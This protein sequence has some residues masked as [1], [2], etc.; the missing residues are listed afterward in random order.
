LNL[1]LSHSGFRPLKRP[2]HSKAPGVAAS[3]GK[4]RSLK[5]TLS[6]PEFLADL[7]PLALGPVRH[8]GEQ[9]I[10]DS[11]VRNAHQED[12][13]ARADFGQI[14]LTAG[15]LERMRDLVWPEHWL[16]AVLVPDPP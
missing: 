10:V 15:P 2:E 8:P 9:R 14:I 1:N 5:V 13:R 12:M 11:F 7:F 16:E 3:G 4:G 6:T